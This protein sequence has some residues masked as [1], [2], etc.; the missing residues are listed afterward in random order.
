MRGP[1]IS[2]GGVATSI[3]WGLPLPEMGSGNRT[4]A[5]FGA[6]V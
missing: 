3:L 5:E 4:G 1:A 2:R 6:A